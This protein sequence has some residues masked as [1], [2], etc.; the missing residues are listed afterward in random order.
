MILATGTVLVVLS[1]LLTAQDN[2][3][4]A[5]RCV[6]QALRSSVMRYNLCERIQAVVLV[7]QWIVEER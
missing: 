2:N 4:S 5:D 3:I 7:S 6:R 1:E